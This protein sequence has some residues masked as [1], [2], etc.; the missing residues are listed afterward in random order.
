M[1]RQARAG[2]SL[3]SPLTLNALV[4]DSTIELMYFSTTC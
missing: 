1:N 2:S 4:L 3:S